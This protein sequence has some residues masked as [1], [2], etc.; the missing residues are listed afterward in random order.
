[1]CRNVWALGGQ[2]QMLM[3]TRNS[4]TASPADDTVARLRAAAPGV[5]NVTRDH[6]SPERDDDDY[7]DD[8]DDDDARPTDPLEAFGNAKVRRST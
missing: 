4:G 5:A 8:D 6:A 3:E 7:D 1:M 2:V